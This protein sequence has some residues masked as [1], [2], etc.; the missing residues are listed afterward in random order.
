MLTAGVISRLPFRG[1]SIRLRFRP[2]SSALGW[3]ALSMLACAQAAHAQNEY[4]DEVFEQ[5]RTT[6][7][8]IGL[9]EMP[10]ARMAPDGDMSLTLGDI[11]A[12]QWRVGLGFQ[13]L[14]WLETSFRYSHIP[15][16]FGNG[17]PLFDRSFGMKV[18]LFQETPYSP[19]VAIGARDI[20]GTGVFGQEFI[21]LSKR[22]W[23]VDL[24]AG[25][26]WGRLAS[27]EMFENP[28]GRIFPSFNIRNNNTG[29]GGTV[30]FGQLFHGPD[31]S[32]FGGINWQTPIENLNLVAEYS[33]DRY[34][35]ERTNTHFFTRAPV[36][37]G[38]NYR[39]FNHVSVMAGYF[40]GTTWGLA[41]SV[42]FDPK[43]PLYSE[44]FSA[45]PP[46]PAIRSPEQ[47]QLSLDELNKKTPIVAL[48][49]NGLALNLGSDPTNLREVLAAVPSSAARD[50]EVDGRTLAIDVDGPVDMDAQCRIYAQ[51]VGNSVAGIDTIALTDLSSNDGGVVLCP[52]RSHKDQVMAEVAAANP[53]PPGATPDAPVLDE[54]TLQ[55][56]PTVRDPVRAEQKIRDDAD[57]Q[58]L[59]IRGVQVKNNTVLVYVSNTKYYFEDEALGRLAR[60]LMSDTP[61]TVEIFRIV[62][63]Y[64]G[65][66]VREVRLLRSDLERVITMYAGAA[67]IRDTMS[68]LNAP[69][70]NP[71]LDAQDSYPKWGWSIAPRLARSF[72]DPKAPAR[73]G[74]FVDL[75]GYLEVAP[76]L[77]FDTILEGAVYN[78]LGSTFPSDSGLPHVRSDFGFYY[79][80]GANGISVLQ[81]TYR[82]RLASDVYAEAKAG[83]LEDMFMGYGGQVLWR[84]NGERWAIGADVYQVYQRGFDRLFDLRPYNTVTGHL[85]VYYESPWY[86]LNFQVH[87]GRYLAGDWGG[88][89]QVSREFESGVEIGAFATFT[90]VPFSQFGEGSFDKGVIVRIPLEWMVP[91]NTQSLGNLD[92]RP[93]SRDGGQRLNYDDSLYDETKRYSYR[94][95]SDHLDNVISP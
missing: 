46:P 47:R 93:L 51:V 68:V 57:A 32:V 67:E 64:H 14:P 13:M 75:S 33:P 53:P 70:D 4:T 62:S 9:L 69:L 90:N 16:F 17:Q 88:T 23:D 3:A 87:G 7:G 1:A 48:N 2:F 44:R 24:T 37:V 30:A 18:R 73:F 95:I 42:H 94:E 5:N 21:V 55:F 76:G 80:D 43:Q 79:K 84:P 50:Y 19:S 15:N 82:N 89:F 8:D 31:T 91:V 25:L 59:D 35:Q 74:V 49:N 26:G 66:P 52:V 85:N 92:F 60:V 58:D 72:F 77:T 45:P 65:V 11:N 41:V 36:N 40:Y 34:L 61:P 71:I 86:G 22:L 78:N 10:S 20:V 38:L 83:Y 39:P 6:Y 63:V 27:T 81:M 56:R 28:F 54:K 29:E 12:T